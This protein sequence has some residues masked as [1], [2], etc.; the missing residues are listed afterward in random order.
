MNGCNQLKR[1]TLPHTWLKSQYDDTQVKAIEKRV[2]DYFRSICPDYTD[3]A[4]WE[5]T[6]LFYKLREVSEITGIPLKALQ[7]WDKTGVLVADRL[8]GGRRI[9]T[10][11]HIRM[12]RGLEV[13]Q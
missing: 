6:R 12:A 11:E 8:P 7:Q 3:H 10:K 4:K 13:H 9:Y 1:E 2:R 5:I